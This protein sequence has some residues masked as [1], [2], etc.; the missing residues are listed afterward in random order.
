M[1]S[2]EFLKRIV[3]AFRERNLLTDSKVANKFV[4]WMSHI[5]HDSFWFTDVPVN[6]N[7][8]KARQITANDLMRL[9]NLRIYT[10]V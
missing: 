2:V 10:D 1:I 3:L 8:V 4:R 6:E 9:S 7:F 5:F